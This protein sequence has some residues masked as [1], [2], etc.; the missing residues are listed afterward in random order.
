[1]IANIHAN[2]GTG[3]EKAVKVKGNQGKNW[4]TF[5]TYTLFHAVQLINGEKMAVGFYIAAVKTCP[6]SATAC[7]CLES[8][9]VLFSRE[10]LCSDF[11][12]LTDCSCLWS[13]P[14]TPV[15]GWMS[16]QTDLHLLRHSQRVFIGTPPH[17]NS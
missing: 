5:N 9:R 11:I 10:E 12:S 4:I 7:S 1:M 3:E 13:D 6:L 17:N 14:R 16:S 8:D 2:C 15:A